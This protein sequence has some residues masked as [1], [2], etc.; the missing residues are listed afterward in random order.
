[1][2]QS[3][4]YD[5]FSKGCQSCQQGKWLCIFL[6]Y[7]CNANCTFCPSPFKNEDKI[8]SAFGNDPKRILEGIEGKPFNA[9]SFS[10]GDCLLVFD[11]LMDWLFY[12]KKNRPDIYY[13]AYTSGLSADEDKM[14]KMARVGLNEIRF[15]IAAINYNSASILEKIAAATGIFEKVAVEIPSIPTDYLKIV[16]ILPFLDRCN[17]NYLNLH[18]YI[19]VPEDPYTQIAVTDTFILNKK[20]EL[21]YDVFSLENTK[22][23]KRFCR[24]NKLKIQVNNCSL[25]KK[26]NQILHR[27]LA[28]GRI[29]KRE[30]EH[31][32]QDGLLETY[33]VH[34]LKM[35]SYEI[36]S[37]LKHKEYFEQLEKYFVNPEVYKKRGFKESK[38][39]IAKFSLLPPLDVDSKRVLLEVRIIK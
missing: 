10:G 24:K 22:K 25:Q 31:L 16:E 38:G 2:N 36:Q 20:T 33:L 7:L 34:P 8:V 4:F 26:E 3:R 19:L 28:M 18:E 17:V 13:W 12:F 9:I 37:L 6:T 39:T 5:N 35:A 1:M 29:F 30:Y 11:R 27:R 21:K 23:I 32:T 14:V 15:N